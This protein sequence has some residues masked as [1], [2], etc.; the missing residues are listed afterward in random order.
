MINKYL[1][2]LLG[3]DC[4]YDL[5]LNNSKRILTLE[6]RINDMTISVQD[7]VTEVTDISTSVD[8]VVARVT[9]L[10][11]QLAAMG[12]PADLQPV[13]DALDALKTK[14]DGIK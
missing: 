7:L 13:K 9:D 5:F 2:R 4:L 11:S 3:I 1:T 8:T 14:I 10:E 12:S 6:K